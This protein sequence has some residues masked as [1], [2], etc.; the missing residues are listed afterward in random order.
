M[1]IKTQFIIT[2]FLFCI[3]LAVIL[4][5]AIITNQ[6]LEKADQIEAIANDV[7]QGASELGYLSQD[8]LIYRE[9]QQLERWRAR[10]AS[11]SAQ[12]DDLQAIRPEHQVLVFH[13]QANKK[14]LKE[15]F[16]SVILALD[17]ES[18]NRNN[19][20]DH[21]T[22]QVSW[23]RIAVQTQGLVSDASRLSQSLRR[24]M[25]NLTRTRSSL[26]YVMVA[27][28]AVF[29]L[30]GY[31]LIYR[32]ILNSLA[33]LRAGTAVIG[34]GNLDFIIEGKRN[35]EIGDL[36]RAFNRMTADLKIVTA[37]KA[38][39][40][41]EITKRKRATDALAASE[42]KYREL[43]E[44]ANSIIIRW[45]KE[46]IIRFINDY[47]LGFFGYSAGD[48]LGRD[49]MTILPEVEESTGRD[50][51]A[52]VK[53]IA[54]HPEQ[55]TYVPSENIRKDGRTVW[56]AWTN[57]A[58]LDE[59]GEVLEILAIGND[60]TSL[61]ETEAAL[62][63][64]ESLYRAIAENFPD[65][66][67]YIFDH[68]LR[69]RVADG[70]GM[71]ALGYS[72]EGL[73]GKT[74]WEGTDEETCRILEQRYPRILAG[75]SLHFET[76][77]KGRELSSAYVP[78]WDDQGKVIAG[79]VV[80][81]DITDRKRSEVAIRAS[82]EEKEVLLKEIHHR[83][84][85]N[86]QIISSLVSL[87]AD[88]SQHFTIRE[89]LQD[90]S[91]RVRSMAMVHEKLYQS[92]DLARVDFA[93]YTHSLLNYLWRSYESESSHR[94]LSL[95][96]EPVLIPVNEAV[97]CGLILNELVS[98]ALKHAFPDHN[99]GEVA[100]SLHRSEQDGVVLGVRDNGRG[101]PAGFDW[102]QAQSLGLRLVHMLAG[103]LHATVDVHS[104]RKGTQF[105]VVFGKPLSG[106]PA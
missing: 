18:G 70:Q 55:Y 50:L 56:V 103:Q 44:T 77:L 20:L 57:K 46:G 99:R 82:L 65:G 96:L 24:Q 71:A 1:R 40:E 27:L 10:F 85:N 7:A 48:L 36:S 76:S 22:L 6:R 94:Q 54:T 67:V 25:D 106:L 15:V 68:D 9:S 73:E 100:V 87:Q 95:N 31:M 43:I 8:Y 33:A 92:T 75:E 39:L 26:I 45:D 72:R 88:Q 90:V 101:L 86:M 105:I 104:D 91:H 69:F 4:V 49:V 14:R 74:I 89:I 3:I 35:D 5:S 98:N 12:V 38:E 53:N 58:I 64:S 93:A 2:T 79:M 37:S 13:I 51:K 28:F 19:D 81:H 16:D 32:R 52:L 62:R 23:S 59:R 83:V 84:K 17:A 66:A 30:A 47:G 80:S 42:R 60:I 29:L 61:K 11:F 63:E 34:S 21:T 102:T 97:P 78:I 41:K